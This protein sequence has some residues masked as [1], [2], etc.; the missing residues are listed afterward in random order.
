M[1]EAKQVVPAASVKVFIGKER[2]PVD[3]TE[4]Q[5]KL[6]LVWAKRVRHGVSLNV[7]YR[8]EDGRVIKIKKILEKKRQLFA[9]HT[10][11]GTY[12]DLRVGEV[13]RTDPSATDL[14]QQMTLKVLKK[15]GR[16]WL[17]A[18]VD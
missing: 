16:K 17:L 12:R 2:V 9:V 7:S 4:A 18:L 6:G 3:L 15:H 5:Q 8:L 14:G 13:L 1:K 11:A 10:T